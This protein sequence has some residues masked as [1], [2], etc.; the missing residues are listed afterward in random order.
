MKIAHY[1]HLLCAALI[2][3]AIFSNSTVD[4]SHLRAWEWRKFVPCLN[5]PIPA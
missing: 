1:L 2:H 3:L 5:T 4:R